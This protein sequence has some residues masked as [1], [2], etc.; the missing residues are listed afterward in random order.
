MSASGYDAPVLEPA[1][2][3]VSRD[4]VHTFVKCCPSCGRPHWHGV[5]A[6]H[7]WSHCAGPGL[8]GPGY[9]LP[10]PKLV[11]VATAVQERRLYKHRPADGGN[12]RSPHRGAR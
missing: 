2:C 10:D 11:R 6:G 5:G 7:R 9:V 12:R 4:G 1:D 8:D 3:L